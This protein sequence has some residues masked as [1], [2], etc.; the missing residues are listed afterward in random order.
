MSPHLNLDMEKRT[1]KERKN[2]SVDITI[3]TALFDGHMTGVPHTVGVYDPTWVD[4]LYRGF[5]RNLNISFD[6]ICLTDKNYR[7]AENIKAVRFNRSV[8]Q[9]GWMSLIE[10]YRPDLCEG[11]RFT[12][13]LDTI[14]TGPLDDIILSP[15]TKLGVCSDPLFPD[16][17]CNAVTI[18][19]PQFC[20][21]FWNLWEGNEVELMKES[22]LKFVDGSGAS[23]EMVLMRNYYGDSPRIDHVYPN[24]I[25][26]YK[27]HIGNEDQLEYKSQIE[28]RQ[29]RLKTASIIY[30]HG[31]PKPHQIADESW[32]QENWV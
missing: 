12:V 24:R 5:E 16:E 20:E 15:V 28:T 32:V 30:F 22:K 7:F 6:F 27:V 19:T 25:F 11:N 10:M 13:G 14:I 17:I 29:S 31:T 3:V 18:S 26:S 9:Y 21:Q 23:S 1:W 4:K 2:Y 8:D